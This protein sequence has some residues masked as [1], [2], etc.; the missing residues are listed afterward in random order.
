MKKI[1]VWAFAFAAMW[2]SASHA[3]DVEGDF[4][5]RHDLKAAILKGPIT[6]KTSSSFDAVLARLPNMEMLILDSPGGQV[7][8]ALGIA[9]KVH[10]LGIPTGVAEEMNC[11]SACS[12]IFLAGRARVARGKLGVHQLSM[13][14]PGDLEATQLVISEILDAFE[15]FGVDT[16]VTKHMLTT[17]P[18]DMYYFS[19]D[20]KTEYLINREEAP[21]AAAVQPSAPKES[22][23]RFVDFKP[24]A[25]YSGKAVFP[26]PG[27]PLAKMYRT[28]VRNG[29][30]DGPNFAGRYSLIEVGCGTSCKIVLLI[31]ASSGEMIRFPLGGEENY[32]LELTYAVD[33]ELLKAVWMDTENG[34]SDT[35][36]KEDYRIEGKNLKRLTQVRFTIEKYGYCSA[37]K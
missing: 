17:R 22:A 21:R 3:L 11:S 27:N 5:I 8:P 29:L 31:D 30:K 7:V 23:L 37:H 19:D 10:A 13:T 15:K 2:V 35:C 36:V 26:G 14:G 20:E 9:R 33:S 32:Q 24:A 25:I 28:R 4:I 1:V 34:D 12:I 16:R 6:E 18:A